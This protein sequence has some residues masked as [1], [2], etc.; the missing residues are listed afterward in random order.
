M[1][2][3]TVPT[4]E[5]WTEYCFTLGRSDFS[6][7]ADDLGS[8]PEGRV[9][10][11][12]SL[13]PRTTAEYVT[14]LFENSRDLAARYTPDQIG[15]ATWFIFGIA[16]EYFREVRSP[17]NPVH[18][19]LRCFE[20]VTT[21]YLDLYDKLCNH[22]GFD[23]KDCSGDQELDGAV[24][25]IW[26]MSCIEGAVLFP[27]ESPLLFDAGLAILKTVLARCRT[28]SC[29]KSA[30]HALG[31]VHTFHPEHAEKIIGDFLDLR[32]HELPEWLADYAEQ[33]RVGSVQ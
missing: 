9:R 6:N 4:F 24:Y 13:S 14:R 16:S 2:D 12:L 7:S 11:F 26:D 15:D 30:L 18:L 33:A 31:H 29:L 8:V 3:D 28:G 5:E 17:A 20:S 32:E 25:M 21:L 23:W 27:E 19:Q 22:K 10:R 1:H